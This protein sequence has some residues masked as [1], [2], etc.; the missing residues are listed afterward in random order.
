MIINRNGRCQQS[1]GSPRG[2][3]ELFGVV[4]EISFMF[5]RREYSEKYCF[6]S[7]VI[8]LG[9]NLPLKIFLYKI[10]NHMFM[11]ESIANV[12]VN[13][14]STCIDPMLAYCWTT[15]VDTGSTLSQ[16]RVNESDP[17]FLNSVSVSEPSVIT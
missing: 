10:R 11:F 7:K 9:R 12:L 13:L 5:I 14:H 2:C 3:P 15:V 17:P 4:P 1:S 16:H 6:T 8:I